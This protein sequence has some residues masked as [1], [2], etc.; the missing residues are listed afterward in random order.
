MS[1]G[2]R[3]LRRVVAEYKIVRCNDCYLY[4]Y[5]EIID[6]RDENSLAIIWDEQTNEFFKGCPK[7]HTDGCLTD[8]DPDYLAE[9]QLAAPIRFDFDS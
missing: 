3:D 9:L 5:V 1:F 6:E 4:F 7:C 2:I 8:I